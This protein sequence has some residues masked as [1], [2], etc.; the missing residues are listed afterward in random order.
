MS[1]GS[2][3]PC[4]TWRNWGIPEVMRWVCIVPALCLTLGLLRAQRPGD[5]RFELT[6]ARLAQRWTR[7]LELPESC[8]AAWRGLLEIG[9]PAVQPLV[10]TTSDPRPDVVMRAIWV[11]GLL[12]EDGEAALPHLRTLAAGQDRQLSIAARW[13][14]DRI[15][16]RGR[17]LVDYS[18]NSIMH[19]DAKG[20]VL[21]EIDQL[22]GPWH[23]EPVGDGRLLVSEYTGGRVY[24]LD[25][26]GKECWSF[27]ELNNPY[28]AQRLPNGN[29]LVADAG[30]QRL[31]EISP[32]GKVIWEKGKLK[33][34]VWVRR[35]PDG[36]M[37][38]AEQNGDALELDPSGAIM[39][40]VT[41]VESP[42][43]VERLPDGGLLVA[44]YRAGKLY[45]FGP[46]TDKPRLSLGYAQAQAARRRRDGHTL[47]ARTKEWV[48][49]DANGK[50]IWRRKASYAVGIFW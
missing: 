34:P 22:R 49:L 47:L 28:G 9:S 30:N 4:S 35:M 25:A 1:R 18:S 37:L 39:R 7:K 16:F 31:V 32:A 41:G 48:E 3:C 33:R 14:I 17:L 12:R 5:E 8:A 46:D 21:R 50:E 24:E 13:A 19:L 36:H 11:L 44:A 15:A 40:R 27:A 10:A 38:V 26:K 29:T 42:M 2:P 45:E 23:A 20:E 6:P 43:C